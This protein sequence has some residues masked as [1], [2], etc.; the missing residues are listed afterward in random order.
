MDG[1]AIWRGRRQAAGKPAAAVP[2]IEAT[3]PAPAG[4]R[5]GT[6]AVLR[7][8]DRGDQLLPLDRVEEHFIGR[9]GALSAVLP[10]RRV[11]Y[12]Y[13][14]ICIYLYIYIYIYI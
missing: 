13:M 4:V 9:L 12:V 14:Y 3:S 5:A 2:E 1:S 6:C 7:T 11:M 8:H 10:D